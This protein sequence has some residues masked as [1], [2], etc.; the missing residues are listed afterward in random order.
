[1]M[2]LPGVW[3]VGGP[4]KSHFFDATVYLLPCGDDL[5]LIDCGT[6]EGHAQIVENIRS[7]GFDPKK[8]TR[9]WATHGHYDHVG[10]A[11]M[12]WEESGAK[13]YLHPADRRQ[14]EAGDSL[15]TTASLLYG[16][17][18]EPLAVDGDI[19][20]GD[21]F[22]VD[23][24]TVSVLHTP[25]HSPGS[26]CFVLRHRNGTVT[27]FAGD[28]LHGGC[29]P[30]IGSDIA[31]WRESLKKLTDRHFDYFT[32]GHMNPHLLCDA[33]ERIRCLAQS[34]GNYFMPWFKDFYR[35]YSY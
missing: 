5:F 24:G 3:Q 33:D 10:G 20:E 9:I 25:G 27:L 19:R 28:T 15:K 21:E 11:G 16:V 34:F 26:C 1:M 18:A 12:F 6:R 4:S 22:T 14:V 8:I 2:L 17:E 7:A 29:H 30:D 35:H 31:V 23:A 32:F 13:L